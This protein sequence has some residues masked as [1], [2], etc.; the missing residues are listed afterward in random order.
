[1]SEN[2]GQPSTPAVPEGRT[3]NGRFAKGNAGGPGNPFARQT[4]AYRKAFASAV[5]PEEMAALAQAM[6]QKALEGDVA[7]ARLVCSYLMGQPAPSPDPDT[8]DAHEL[9]VRRESVATEE[10]VRAVSEALPASLMCEIAQAAEP[11]ALAHAERFLKEGLRSRL[12]FPPAGRGHGGRPDPVLPWPETGLPPRLNKLL[13][14]CPAWT[15]PGDCPAGTTEGYGR[16]IHEMAEGVLA[17]LEDRAGMDAD[18]GRW[19]PRPVTKR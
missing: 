3:A 2:N 6:K 11:A 5:S 18:A 9:R 14:M 1:M 15:H 16:A 4:A 13:E 7:A 12:S 10:D 17:R 8:L 19:L